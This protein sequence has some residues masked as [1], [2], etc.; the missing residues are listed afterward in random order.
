MRPINLIPAEEQRRTRGVGSRSG[1]L[2]FLLVGAL[3]LAL[4]GVVMLIHYSNQVSDHEANLARLQ[5]EKTAAT[6]RADALT[7]YSNFA[8]VTEPRTDTIAELANA[9]FDWARVIRQLSLVLPSN[10][11]FTNLSAS[12]GGGGAAEGIAV[13][14]PSMAIGG[15][16]PSQDAVAAFVAAL[17]QIDGV[18]RVSLQNSTVSESN[19]EGSVSG[20]SACAAG[21]KTVFALIVAFDFAPASPDGAAVVAEAA[22]AEAESESEGS[23]EESSSEGSESS[24]STESSTEPESSES[25]SGQSATTAEGGAAG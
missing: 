12:S 10:V 8:S 19:S 2:P 1:S 9:R 16:A 4:I 24:S 15:C 14:G 23:S 22:Q 5:N 11:Y 20:A 3:A 18:T 25:T 21:G 13:S 7:P 6:A 17:K